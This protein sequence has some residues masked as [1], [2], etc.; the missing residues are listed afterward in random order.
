MTSKNKPNNLQSRLLLAGS[1]IAAIYIAMSF[2]V[3]HGS[4]ISP[5]ENNAQVS[6]VNESSGRAGDVFDFPRDHLLHQPQSVV[7]NTSDFIEWL[8]WTGILRDI[9]TGEIYGFQYTLFHQNIGPGM[10]GYVNHVAISDVYNSR[11]PRNRYATLPDQA[12][13]TNGTDDKKGTYWRYQDASTTLTYWEDQDAWNIISQGNV[14]Q[15]G[16]QGHNLSL[17]LT[18]ANDKYDYYLE[19][20]GGVTS[21]GACAEIDQ[22]SMLGRTYYYSHPAMTTTGTLSID[23][24]MVQVRGDSWFDHQWGGFGQ[25]YPAWDWFSLRLDD[26]GFMMLFNFKD[27]EQRD[28]PDQRG[29][30]YIDPKG[31]VTWWHG[32]DA[33]N[34]TVTR[35]WTSDLFGFRYPMEWTIDTPVGR[36]ALQPYFDEQ[37]MNVAQ[38][39]VKYWE[40]L[41]HVRS[42]D[43]SGP[44]IGTA[45][46]ELA[47]YAPIFNE[48]AA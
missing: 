12:M 38:G 13:I 19:F 6:S 26:G 32:R 41:M 27:P 25:C 33:A 28:I 7:S 5:A 36:Y 10:M 40:G 34:L 2:A 42:G 47:G 45:F 21:M 15:D 16:G 31:N 46:M 48:T 22:R 30:T 4:A 29:L 23:G 35:W 20:P 8:Y 44:Q 39:E 17:N 11:H 24:H 9:K 18:M 43:Q 14:S 1:L 3:W 37:T